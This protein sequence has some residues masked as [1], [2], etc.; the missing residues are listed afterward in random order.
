[1]IAVVEIAVI[2]PLVSVV[3]TGTDV[4]EPN[5]PT[6][7]PARVSIFTPVTAP[8]LIFAV[9]TPE[10]ARP[11]VPAPVMGDPPAVKPS[12]AV[13]LVTPL[14]VGHVVRQSPAIQTLA[15]PTVPEDLIFPFTSNISPGVAVPIP[16][17]PPEAMV[18]RVALFVL[19]L[20]LLASFVPAL[21]APFC[22]PLITASVMP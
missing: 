3:T 15:A 4:A 13:T 17:L 11:I 16:T 5:V 18:I 14:P 19:R 10:S 2:R 6:V 9:V 1:M 7:I 21:T 8:S 20:K 12:F 22:P